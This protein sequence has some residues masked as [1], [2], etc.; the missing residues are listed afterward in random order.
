MGAK[1]S[2]IGTGTLTIE[3]VEK[4][5]PCEYSIIPDRIV[6]GTFIIAS[7]IFDGKIE[8]EGVR[9]EHLEAFG[10]FIKLNSFRGNKLIDWLREKNWANFAH[11]YNGS[12]YKTNKYDTKLQ[13]AYDK[14]ND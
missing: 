4:L 3:G 10:K 7:I 13:V 2:G 14:Y 11:A 1:I 12:G 8:V 5:Y 9:R 6:A